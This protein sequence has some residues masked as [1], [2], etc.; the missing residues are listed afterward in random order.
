MSEGRKRFK[1]ET[2]MLGALILPIGLG[3]AIH[4]FMQRDSVDLGGE[5]SDREQCKAPADACL[6]IEGQGV[7]TQQCAGPC[8]TREGSTTSA[9]WATACPPRW[10]RRRPPRV[11]RAAADLTGTVASLA[12][13]GH[14]RA[15]DFDHETARRAPLA[16][17]GRG[18][19]RR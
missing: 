10:R 4:S 19:R 7:C 3:I 13:G 11:P 8:R 2:W 17:R 12:R 1:F 16:G 14:T 5:C 18:V 15:H 9:G 6:E